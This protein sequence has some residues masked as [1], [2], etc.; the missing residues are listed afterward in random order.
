MHIKGDTN[1]LNSQK[2]HKK[3][4]KIIF[5]NNFLKLA[6]HFDNVEQLITSGGKTLDLIIYIIINKTCVASRLQK[7]ISGPLGPPKFM[8]S[9]WL[10]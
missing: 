8:C 1:T 5:Q 3:V 2:K 7:Y 4:I 6:G 10:H 9:Y